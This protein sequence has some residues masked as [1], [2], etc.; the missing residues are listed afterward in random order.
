VRRTFNTAA[1][2]LGIVNYDPWGMRRLIERMDLCWRLAEHERSGIVGSLLAILF[3]RDRQH[4]LILN[5]QR[6]ATCAGLFV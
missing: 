1:T 5:Q 4:L 3:A 2:A 6:N